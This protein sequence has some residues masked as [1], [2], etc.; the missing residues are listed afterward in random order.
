[1]KLALA[2]LVSGRGTNL[3]AVLDAV[4]D[5]RLSAVISGVVCDR[6]GALALER[7]AKAGVPTALVC[8]EDYPSRKEWEVALAD[9]VEA[10]EPRPDL[11]VLAGFMRI[12]SPVFLE[13]FGGQVINIHPSLLPAF[14]GLDAQKQALDRGVKF[15]GCTVHYVDAGCDTGPII[16]QRVVPV[17]PDDDVDSLSERILEQ[18]HELLVEVLS[19]FAARWEEEHKE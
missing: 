13:R 15:S 4:A 16:G 11:V 14:P 17:L 12:L 1:M 19:G 2:V 9:A 7:A 3:Q 5:G 18:E 8:M 6:R 10:L